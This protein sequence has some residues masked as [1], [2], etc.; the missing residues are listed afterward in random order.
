MPDIVPVILAAGDSSRMGFPKALLPLGR[1]TFLTHILKTLEEIP[2]PGV[3]VILGRDAHRIRPHLASHRVRMLVNPHPELGQSSS[4]HMALEN[5][6]RECSGCL[7]WPVDQPLVSGA[8]VHELIRLFLNS[9]ASLA[10]PAC[11]RKAGHPAIFGKALIGELLAAPPGANPKPV[12][13]RHKKGAICLPT[14][15]K[16]TIEDCDT[17]EDYLRITGETLAA[18]LARLQPDV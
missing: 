2:L 1:D 4:L 13:A 10:L 9:E 18:V 12:V 14:D 17:P 7:V 15:E 8:L 6:P 5:L 3:L 16:G 11:Q